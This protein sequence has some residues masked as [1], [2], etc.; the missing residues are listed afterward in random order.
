VCRLGDI[1][2]Q[3]AQTFSPSFDVGFNLANE[4][5]P[6]SAFTLHSAMAAGET[7]RRA[8]AHCLFR[9]ALPAARG[10]ARRSQAAGQHN[11]QVMQ[12][13]P[14]PVATPERSLACLLASVIGDPG[15]PASQR[16]TVVASERART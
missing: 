6:P 11:G 1:S 15:R 12:A 5:A 2:R 4:R 13:S 10:V 7:D 14:A 8:S 3:I 9:I 16:P